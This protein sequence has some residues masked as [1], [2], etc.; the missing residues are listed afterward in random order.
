[1]SPRVPA[2]YLAKPYSPSELLAMVKQFLP[3][4]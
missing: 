2:S 1:M 4:L 3:G